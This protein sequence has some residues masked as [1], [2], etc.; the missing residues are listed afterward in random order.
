[1]R[2]LL[3]AIIDFLTKDDSPTRVSKDQL[4]IFTDPDREDYWQSCRWQKLSDWP[5]VY[6]LTGEGCSIWGFLV[7][8]RGTPESILQRNGFEVLPTSVF[9][10]TKVPLYASETSRYGY[11]IMTS[12]KKVVM[13]ANKANL[14][15]LVREGVLDKPRH[16]K[17]IR[18]R[19]PDR[20]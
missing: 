18:H 5:V 12:D 1:M 4:A 20:R 7:N 14:W 2:K 10:K 13:V 11:A 15:E 9:P 3:D 19:V 6:T 17:D 8:M 16:L